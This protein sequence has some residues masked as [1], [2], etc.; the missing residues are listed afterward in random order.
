[1]DTQQALLEK[2]KNV[3][4]FD[5]KQGSETRLIKRV[6]K[7]LKV[8]ECDDREE[9]LL[10]LA[11]LAAKKGYDTLVDVDIQS[12]KV[13]NKTYK[14]LVWNGTAVPVDIKQRK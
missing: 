3:D 6:E 2:A 7:P 11:F 8:T 14:K 10:R 9:T 4:T 12:Q 5:K 1:M 13:G